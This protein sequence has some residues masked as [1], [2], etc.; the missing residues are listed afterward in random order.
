MT[1]VGHFCQS[2]QDPQLPQKKKLCSIEFL[3]TYYIVKIGYII[4][5]QKLDAVVKFD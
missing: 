5:Y 2:R 1:K 3:T 4:S